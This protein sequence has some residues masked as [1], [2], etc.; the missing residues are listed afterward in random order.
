MKRESDRR[1]GKGRICAFGVTG[2][3]EG[4][5]EVG[6]CRKRAG[7]LGCGG[8]RVECLETEIKEDLQRGHR[9]NS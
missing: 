4:L 2:G 3:V 8:Q 6:D 5:A 7:E 9:V 1:D